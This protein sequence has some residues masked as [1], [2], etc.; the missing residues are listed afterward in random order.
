MK[1]NETTGLPEFDPDDTL[2][3]SNLIDYVRVNRLLHEWFE[4]QP[5][6]Y[7]KSCLEGSPEGGFS[8]SKFDR[9]THRA[10]LIGIRPIETDNKDKILEDFISLVRSEGIHLRH[11]DNMKK[12]EERARRLFDG[13]QN[14]TANKERG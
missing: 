2:A 10:Y 9:D 13:M 5:V 6:V 12:L 1:T 3:G 14:K 4:K 7:G 11:S 8:I